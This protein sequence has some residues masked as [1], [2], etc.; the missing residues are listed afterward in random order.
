MEQGWVALCRALCPDVSLP[1]CCINSIDKD[2]YNPTGPVR[3]RWRKTEK[4]MPATQLQ[5]HQ[6]GSYPYPYATTGTGSA[7]TV[8][9]RNND[10]YLAFLTQTSYEDEIVFLY[11]HLTVAQEAA[12]IA[13]P[14][15]Q[16]VISGMS[17]AIFRNTIW[18]VQSTQN[19]D[20][21]IGI[22]PDTGNHTDTITI[23]PRSG[24]ALAYN[25]ILFIRSDGNVLEAISNSGIVIGSVNVPLGSSIQGLTAAPW[26]YV[27]SDTVQNRLM[28]L[29]VFGNVIAK[30]STP[31]G[32]A[33]GITAVAYDNIA[34]YDQVSQLPTETGAWGAPGTPY[35]PDTLWNP[36][37]WMMRHNIYL[38]NELDQTIYFGYFY[39]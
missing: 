3:I 26:S 13:T 2:I 30:C 38:A 1:Q 31:P 5:F 14:L 18:A 20:T 7:L 36:A 25:G 15:D 22:D 12:R 19:Q 16:D 6:V 21:I 33:G 4:I 29:N 35:H 9:R 23:P 32:P 39:E 28:V 8:C 24:A 10:P 34:D 17:Y 27:A 11:L 37:P